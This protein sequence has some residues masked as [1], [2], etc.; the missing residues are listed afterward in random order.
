MKKLHWSGVR[1]QEDLEHLVG[2]VGCKQ[3]FV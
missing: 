2:Q 3:A 1:G